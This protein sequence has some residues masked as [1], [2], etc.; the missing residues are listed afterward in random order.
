VLLCFDDGGGDS[1]D[2]NDLKIIQKIP[3]NIP[4]KHKIKKTTENSHIGR[5]TH[6][7]DNTNVKVQYSR[8]NVGTGVLCTVS[9]NYRIAA[10]LCSLGKWFLL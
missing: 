7:S 8:F 2:D 6:T 5:G 1:D 3:S 10:T 4:G 9:I